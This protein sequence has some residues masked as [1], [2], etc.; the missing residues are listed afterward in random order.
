MTRGLRLSALLG[1]LFLAAA[2]W[3]GARG[4]TLY[5]QRVLVADPGDIRLGDLVQAAGDPPASARESLALAVASISSHL[6]YVP[7]RLYRDQLEEAFGR[8]SIFVGS[9]SLVIPRGAVADGNIPLLDKL[10]DFLSD[11]GAL[12][13]D[14]ADID[15]R[16]IRVT[17]TLPQNPAPSFQMVRSSKTSVEVSFTLPG[18]GG[19]ASGRIVLGLKGD[20]R[21]AAA[22]IGAN[23]PVT[24]IFRKGP[25][26]IEMQGKAQGAAAIGDTVSVLV[27]DSKRTFSG[28][29]LVGKAVDVELP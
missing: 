15:I 19:Q 29:L 20:A 3:S 5:I 1:L 2:A 9:R 21:A 8:D 4:A 18:D 6:L 28:R 10:V 14:I 13:N 24:V 23:D 16:S 11:S 26:T 22:D 27:A 7:C 17:G 25:I 12:G